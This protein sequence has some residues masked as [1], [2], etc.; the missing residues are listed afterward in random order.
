MPEKVLVLAPDVYLKGGIQRYVR[1]QILAFNNH[2][3][4]STYI[5]SL[6]SKDEGSFEDDIQVDLVRRN[7]TNLHNLILTVRLLFFCITNRPKIILCAHINISPLAY[8]LRLASGAKIITNVY[9]YEL[10]T[11]VT[12]LKKLAICRSDCIIGDCN[13]ILSFFEKNFTT[14]VKTALLFDP[15][16]TSVFVPAD[17]AEMNRLRTKYRIADKNVILTVGRLERNKGHRLIISALQRNTNWFYVIAGD[18]SARK[19][20]QE[21]TK[22]LGLTD[23]VSFLGRVPEPDLAGLYSLADIVALISEKSEGEGEGLPLG[24]IE[25]MSCG[26][27]IICGSKDGSVDAIETLGF[28]GVFADDID[29]FS[30]ALD[31]FAP[32]MENQKST[33]I[34]NKAIRRFDVQK[35]VQSFISI[36]KSVK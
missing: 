29:Q 5:V 14:N 16:D 2:S 11:S 28:E 23:R 1:A 20:L 36:I 21:L 10:W 19:E 15:V 30:L 34:R 26:T 25:A 7:N 31:A 22:K 13:H 32:E 35:F 8:L 4:F 24:L 27:F 3:E 33:D 18:G 12:K 9:G 6:T 17:N